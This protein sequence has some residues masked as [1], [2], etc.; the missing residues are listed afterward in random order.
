[1]TS[2]RCNVLHIHAPNPWGDLAALMCPREVPIVMTWHS[3]IVRQRTAMLLYRYVQRAVLKRTDQI[4]VFTPFH[5]SSSRQLLPRLTDAKVKVIPIGIDASHLHALP[6]D[7]ATA[8]MIAGQAKG[9][10]VVLTVGRHVPY[11]GYEHLLAA[12]AALREDALLVMIGA[13]PLSASLAALADRLGIAERTMFLGEVGNRELATAYRK[14]DVFCLP[15]VEQSEAFGM[16]SA[17]AMSFGKPTIVCELG[18]GVNFLNQANLT[19]LTVP[20]REPLAL[21]SAIDHLLSD[22]ALRKRLGEAAKEWVT[23]Q[24]SVTAMKR[25]TIAVY[26]SLLARVQ[27]SK[28]SHL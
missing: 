21:A 28:V 10:R 17:E 15:S 11:K 9:R 3:D 13:G 1:M 5:Y 8:T 14:C 20:P 18:N 24:F 12:F 27:A 16:A 19:G 25:E 26:R 23:S 6:D 22:H 4:V 7:P 2:G